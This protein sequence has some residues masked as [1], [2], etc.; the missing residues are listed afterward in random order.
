MLVVGVMFYCS[1]KAETGS[2]QDSFTIFGSNTSAIKSCDFMPENARIEVSPLQYISPFTLLKA[3]DELPDSK[4]DWEQIQILKKRYL[5]EFELK[6]AVSIVSPVGELTKNEVIEL[7][8]CF[9]QAKNFEF[10]RLIADDEALLWFLENNDLKGAFKNTRAYHEPAF[11]EFITPFFLNSYNALICNLLERGRVDYHLL[12][13]MPVLVKPGI[14]Q[15]DYSLI[16]NKIQSMIEDVKLLI[17]DSRNK[18]LSNENVRRVYSIHNMQ[19]FNVLDQDVFQADLEMFVRVSMEL[20]NSFIDDDR[21]CFINQETVGGVLVALKELN[22][23][24]ADVK[25]SLQVPIKNPIERFG[26]LYLPL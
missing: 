19:V 16:V 6:H 18:V 12:Y 21:K 8:D 23:C 10:H 13:K 1:K 14:R 11:R 7:F 9:L 2:N 17:A 20:V 26:L 25:K 4:T 15:G 22:A 3:E 5:A 24:N